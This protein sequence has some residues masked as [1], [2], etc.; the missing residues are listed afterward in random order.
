MQNGQ[1]SL[2]VTADHG[3]HWFLVNASPDLRQQVL[4]A[5]QL[6]PAQGHLRHSPIA[7]VILTN[8][9][10][11]AVAG[12]LSMREGQAFSIHAHSRVLDLLEMNPI[13]NVLNRDLVPRLAITP[14]AV[15][16]PRLPDG[17]LSGLEVEAFNVAGKVAWYMEGVTGI[18]RETPGD[19]LGLTFRPKGQA[20][21]VIHVLTACARVDD[22]L[23]QRL[24]G[25]DLVFF[26][27][28]LWTDDEMIR[29]GL[30]RKTGQAMGHVS[31]S[32]P[33]GAIAGLADLDIAR[34]VF[35]HI[36]NSNPVLLPTSA[37]RQAAEAAGWTIPH[38]FE[39]FAP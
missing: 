17:C 2:A 7:G 28:T 34:K 6:R 25:A 12:L 15:F 39:V 20:R 31:M 18:T 36:N 5:P 30:A 35:V 8:G 29:Q 14:G 38:A 9:E 27:G 19:T 10:V 11:D 3:V 1:V 13:F 37:E 23:R 26:D 32:G 4:S 33:E 21:P 24:A 16:E 22:A